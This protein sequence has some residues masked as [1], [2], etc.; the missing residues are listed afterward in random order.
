M[1]GMVLRAI[2][3]QRAVNMSL[4]HAICPRAIE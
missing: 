3:V 2:Q 4:I 1:F